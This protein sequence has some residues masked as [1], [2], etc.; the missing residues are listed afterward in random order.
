M[1]IVKSLFSGFRQI[2]AVAMILFGSLLAG[3]ASFGPCGG[4]LLANEPFPAIFFSITGL[5]LIFCS[6]FVVRRLKIES[7]F[8]VIIYLFLTCW[9]LSLL[10][11]LGW[12]VRSGPPHAQTDLSE[13]YFSLLRGV[14]AVL[15][16]IVFYK[17]AG[18]KNMITRIW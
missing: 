6:Y 4:T 8:R 7:D 11:E 2:V 18:T 13:L 5:E 1:Q 15:N 17:W 9:S 14:A 3:D 10:F 16:L 12:L